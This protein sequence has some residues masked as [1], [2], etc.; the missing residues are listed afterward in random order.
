MTSLVVVTYGRDYRKDGC[1]THILSTKIIVSLILFE[2][3]NSN[4]KRCVS[5]TMIR[6]TRS[7]ASDVLNVYDMGIVGPHAISLFATAAA[8]AAATNRLL[9][10]ACINKPTVAKRML[11]NDTREIIPAAALFYHLI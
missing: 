3:S 11:P 4:S 8:A 7:Y 6:P 10:F 9:S 2:H 5:S 1:S